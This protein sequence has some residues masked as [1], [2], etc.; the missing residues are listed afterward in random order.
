MV[1]WCFERVTLDKAAMRVVND[2]SVHVTHLA[3]KTTRYDTIL[4]LEFYFQH[5]D[6]LHKNMYFMNLCCGRSFRPSTQ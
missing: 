1:T 3:T 6:P 4:T 5:L 2:Y